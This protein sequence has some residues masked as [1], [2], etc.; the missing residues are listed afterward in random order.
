MN[1]RAVEETAG[2]RDERS[3]S[4]RAARAPGIRAGPARGRRPRS[5]PSTRSSFRRF[6]ACSAS[7][8]PIRPRCRSSC[9]CSACCSASRSIRQRFVAASNLSTVLT[10][11]TIIGILG[12][13]PDARHPDRRHRSVGRRHHGDF[14]GRDGPARRHRRRAARS[15]RFRSACCAAS[16]C[17]CLNGVLVTRLRMPPFIV[18]LGT[19]SIFGAL[20]TY[21]SQSETIRSRT[22]RTRR[23]SCNHGQSVRHRRRAHH[24][25]LVPDAAGRGDLLVRAQPHRLTAATSM[26]PATIPKPRGSPASTPT[27]C[28]AAS[29]CSPGSSPRSPAGR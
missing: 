19:W 17:G 14:V 12:I 13:A 24:P 21:Y 16:L 8:T 28:C 5:L 10:Q 6:S 3:L 9:W 29:I 4:R 20:N 18:T 26:R 11:V 1:D 23:R 7:C 22:S 15:S 25:R 2:R 27:A